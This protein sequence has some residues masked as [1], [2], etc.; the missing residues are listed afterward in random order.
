MSVTILVVPTYFFFLIF[1]AILFYFAF[2]YTHCQG[3]LLAGLAA[4]MYSGLTYGLRE[5]R[6][7]HDWVS[8]CASFSV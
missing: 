4:G 5:A 8:R 3:F 2:C 6:G 7:S 1:S